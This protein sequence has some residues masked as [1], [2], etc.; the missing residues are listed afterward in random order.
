MLLAT[1]KHRQW[2]TV[3]EDFI[4][5]ETTGGTLASSSSSSLGVLA[6]FNDLTRFWRQ[7]PRGL[8]CAQT[9]A[10]IRIVISF[11]Y[12]LQSSSRTRSSCSPPVLPF[13]EDSHFH[14]GSEVVLAGDPFIAG[15]WEARRGEEG[16]ARGSLQSGQPGRTRYVNNF[17]LKRR[18]WQIIRSCKFLLVDLTSCLTSS[19]WMFGSIW[20]RFQLSHCAVFSF[21]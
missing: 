5:V 6:L 14:P 20:L 8:H 18:T 9:P 21:Q 12:L 13:K 19:C 7:E 16:P 2:E 1:F 17:Y 11:L 10:S 4:F 15:G 3:Q